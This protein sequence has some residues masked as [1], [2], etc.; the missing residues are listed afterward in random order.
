M[1]EPCEEQAP[2][3]SFRRCFDRGK[4]NKHRRSITAKIWLNEEAYGI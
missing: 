3:I 4:R 1:K 2:A